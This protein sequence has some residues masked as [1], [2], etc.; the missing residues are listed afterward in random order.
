MTDG[1]HHWF[2]W[3]RSAVGPT[4]IEL[5]LCDEDST[6][7]SINCVHWGWGIS[8]MLASASY[9]EFEK[10]EEP[11]QFWT[12]WW[13]FSYSQAARGVYPAPTDK[14]FF[15]MDSTSF[16]PIMHNWRISTGYLW[17]IQEIQDGR[18][19]DH[20]KAPEI[21]CLTI[22]H[23]ITCNSTISTNLGMHNPF[24]MSIFNLGVR[25]RV[26]INIQT[27]YGQFVFTNSVKLF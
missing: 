2:S 19:H 23:R 16:N 17:A 25:N 10:C 5:L 3:W 22:W 15:L 9:L 4:G 13:S 20:R 12:L 1:I 21:Y 24:L 11:I 27:F 18:Q 7:G 26:K 14:V 6:A 8:T